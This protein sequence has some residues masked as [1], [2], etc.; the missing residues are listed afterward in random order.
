[1]ENNNL[2]FK[3]NINCGSCLASV[4]PHLDAAQGICHWDVDMASKDKIL[5]VN[6][7]GITKDQVIETVQRA[8]YK[9]ELINQ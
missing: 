1:M 4:K 3:T 2:K 5:S 8:G 9:I 6:S 7:D